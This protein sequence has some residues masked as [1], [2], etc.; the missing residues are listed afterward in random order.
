MQPQIP[1]VHVR[2]GAPVSTV[3]T[4]RDFS[5]QLASMQAM[6]FAISAL[7][8]LSSTLHGPI[9]QGTAVNRNFVLISSPSVSEAD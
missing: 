2:Q 4:L 7:M 5:Q 8:C 6:Q 3:Y 1:E 9:K